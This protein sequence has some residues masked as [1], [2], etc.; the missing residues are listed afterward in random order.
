MIRA[1]EEQGVLRVRSQEAF[2]NP[3]RCEK[4]EAKKLEYTRE[5]QEAIRTFQSDYEAGI[6]KTY[7]VY[8]SH[9]KRQ[10]RSVYGDDPYRWCRP[11]K[12]AIVLIPEIA[13]TYQTVLRLLPEV[14][15]PGVH[16]EFPA[17]CRGAVMTRWSG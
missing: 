8:G 17:V 15:G 4:Q 11:G 9:R 5:Q 12:Q 16:S 13:L 2:R 6:R 3:V 14:W 1:L 10:D 7:L